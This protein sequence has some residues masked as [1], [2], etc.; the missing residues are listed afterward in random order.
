MRYVAICILAKYIYICTQVSLENEILNEIS[1]G[2]AWLT[3]NELKSGTSDFS[4]TCK[5]REIKS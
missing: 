2:L 1:A 4:F 5:G 3:L